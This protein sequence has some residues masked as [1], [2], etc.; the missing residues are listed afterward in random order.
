MPDI[1]AERPSEEGRS[2]TITATNG[3]SEITAYV[4]QKCCVADLRR[5]FGCRPEPWRRA[6]PRRAVRSR[7]CGCKACFGFGDADDRALAAILHRRLV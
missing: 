5:A 6:Y 1:N 3:D 2:E 7:P 4:R